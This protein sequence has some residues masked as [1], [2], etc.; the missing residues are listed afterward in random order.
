MF[1]FAHELLLTA[2]VREDGAVFRCYNF[3]T[4]FLNLATFYK[5]HQN[6][7]NPEMPYL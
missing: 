6:M 7:E 5:I 2:T 4:F 3:A 1:I